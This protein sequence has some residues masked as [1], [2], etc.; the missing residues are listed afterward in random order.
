[1]SLTQPPSLILLVKVSSSFVGIALRPFAAQLFLDLS[2]RV[3]RLHFF[4]MITTI[5]T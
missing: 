5:M 1:M 3:S 2:Q 4:Q